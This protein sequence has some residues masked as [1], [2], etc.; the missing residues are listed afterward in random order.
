MLKLDSYRVFVNNLLVASGIE[1]IHE[2][3]RMGR[4]FVE[5]RERDERDTD[6][7][8]VS[9]KVE[10]AVE[11]GGEILYKEVLKT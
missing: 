9:F 7:L 10:Q 3:L 4:K 5:E 6:G 2:A 1:S 11:I 8:F